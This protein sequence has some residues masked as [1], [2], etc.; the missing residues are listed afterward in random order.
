MNGNL[1]ALGAAASVTV[2][3]DY[4][5]T[6][7][8]GSSVAGT[9]SSLT[10][11]GSF[12]ANLT[13]L[14]A[15]RTYHFR[16]KAAAGSNTPVYGADQTFTT[17]AASAPSATT[18]PASALTATAATLNG[19]LTS[20]GSS[21]SVTVSFQYGLTTSY[22]STAAGVPSSLT[23]PGTFTASVSALTAGTTYHYRAVAVGSTPVYGADQT[24]TTAAPAFDPATWYAT[25]S[26]VSCHGANR[27]GS[28]AITSTALANV[29]VAQIVAK[30]SPGGS[31]ASFTSSLNATQIS[32]LANWLKITP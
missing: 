8:Y 7:S 18:N 22:G 16:A 31:M 21:T 25:S 27:Q 23:A 6:T 30:L 5:T 9:P 19:N 3:F 15:G 26:C 14:T 32:A 24:F 20:L 2:S 10:S 12:S 4:G 13:G 11:P 17:A 29:T 28:P 1:T